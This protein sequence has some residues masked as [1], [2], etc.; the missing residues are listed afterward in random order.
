MKNTN[1]VTEKDILNEID[2]NFIKYH[3]IHKCLPNPEL[4]DYSNDRDT[5]ELSKHSIGPNGL[6]TINHTI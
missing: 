1:K 6:I 4:N 5:L 2:D 3:K